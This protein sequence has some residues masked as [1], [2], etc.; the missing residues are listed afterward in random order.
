MLVRGVGEDELGD[1]PQP[2]PVRF[3]QEVPEVA[4]RAV[5][6]M[7]LAIVGDVVAVVAQRRR[8]RRGAARA[9]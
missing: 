8:D 9:P 1:D 2:A 4:Q 7:D 6:G 3:A 5:G